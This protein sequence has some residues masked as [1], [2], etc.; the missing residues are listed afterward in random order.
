MAR[1]VP[2]GGGTFDGSV[3]FVAGRS[4]NPVG[5]W[6]YVALTYDGSTLRLFVNGTQVATRAMTG[7]IETTENPLWFGGNHP[8][9]EYFDGLIDEARVYDRALAEAEIRADMA[10]PVAAGGAARRQP[11]EHRC[12]RP[13]GAVAPRGAGRGVFLRRGVGHVGD[14]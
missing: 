4:A 6:S 11:G 13:S 14:G 5:A 7:T 8:Y 9:G 3:Q 1:L 10:T 2:A 12:R